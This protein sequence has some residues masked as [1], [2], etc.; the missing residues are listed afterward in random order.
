MTLTRTKSGLKNLHILKG[1]DLIIY[2]E[3]GGQS[4]LTK[5]DVLNGTGYEHSADIRFWNKLF[6]KFLSD[7]S[8][9]IIAVGSCNT[10]KEISEE[11]IREDLNNVCVVMDRDYSNFWGTVIDHNKIIYTR[12]YSW[13]NELFHADIILNAFRKISI[14]E[15]DEAKIREIIKDAR[16][17]IL[18]QLR[19][20]LKADLVLVAANSSLFCREKPASCFKFVRKQITPP[21]I[22][23][24]RMRQ[25][26]QEKRSDATGV[27][28][29]NP[30][31]AGKID[32]SR[33]VFGKILLVASERIL[34]HLILIEGQKSIPNEYLEKFLCDAFFDWIQEDPT[35]DVAAVYHKKIVSISL[36]D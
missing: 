12:T 2:A 34:H 36:D 6:S 17:K 25:K 23:L 20:L 22:D 32:V 9:K 28:L 31:V 8:F 33:D 18:R 1:V 15:P 26:L 16:C 14:N 29:I 5:E 11:I 7:H 13:E 3:G 27:R 19:H 35:T 4:T 21:E 24:V 10:L 30:P